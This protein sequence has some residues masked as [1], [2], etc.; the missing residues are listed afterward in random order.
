MSGKRVGPLVAAM[1]L[2]AGSALAAS[3]ERKVPET[4]ECVS[5]NAILSY[6]LFGLLGAFAVLLIYRGIRAR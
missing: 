5:G 6:V 1:T 4:L 2:A 3:A